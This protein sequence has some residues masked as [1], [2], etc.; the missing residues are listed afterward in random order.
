MRQAFYVIIIFFCLNSSLFSQ[1]LKKN[2]WITQYS[3]NVEFPLTELEIQKIELAFQDK[4]HLKKI[5]S[6]KAITSDLKDILRNRVQL[7]IE[8]VKDL[9]NLP[10]LSSVKFSKNIKSKKRKFNSKNFNPLLYNFNFNSKQK[11]IYRIDGTNY[12]IL[13][14]PKDLK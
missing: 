2:P 8:N 6:S 11:K 13:I 3:K 5:Y 10:L 12:I 4:N 9:S 1:D 14:N 7:R